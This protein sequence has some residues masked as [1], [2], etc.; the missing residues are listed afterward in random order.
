MWCLTRDE[1]KLWCEAR[2]RPVDKLG[3]PAL[4]ERKHTVKAPTSGMNWSRLHWLA[5]F[6]ISHVEPFD[7]CLL[8]VTQSGVWPSSENFHLFYRM[9]ESYGERRQLHDAP[10][11]LFLKHE[12][13]DLQTFVELALLCGWDFYL[14]PAPG[15]AE[16]FVSHDEFIELRT[17]DGEAIDQVKASLPGS[18]E[19]EISA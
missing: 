18:T 6:L 8:W 2:L 7:E 12:P 5:G 15:Y 11:L 16:A 13:S 3:C 4:V 10:G 9:R 19:V 14:L 17:D 1:S